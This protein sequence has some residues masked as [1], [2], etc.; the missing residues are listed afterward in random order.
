MKLVSLLAAALSLCTG[1]AAS[2]GLTFS[3]PLRA[4]AFTNI[5]R[6]RVR[7]I[8]MNAL[9]SNAP[10]QRRSNKD[11]QPPPV[12]THHLAALNTAVRV[13][14]S[15]GFAVDVVWDDP[16]S[17]GDR[18]CI[19]PK[20]DDPTCT[21]EESDAGRC[22][23]PAWAVACSSKRATG[24]RG[25]M[26]Q[27]GGY[28]GSLAKDEAFLD[29]VTVSN[30]QTV[31]ST[32]TVNTSQQVGTVTDASGNTTAKIYAQGQETREKQTREEFASATVQIF[33]PGTPGAVYDAQA[34]TE[35]TTNIVFPVEKVLEPVPSAAH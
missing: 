25:Y 35:A 4:E 26:I 10:E 17:Y 30:V 16:Y 33:V 19:G 23:Q 5:K 20:P 12:S 21:L 24:Y 9:F 18:P 22:V 28:S 34:W 3:T 29:L 11:Y 8:E 14:K 32:Y 31:T 15:K 27:L 1:C 13:L 2:E 7:T 6:F